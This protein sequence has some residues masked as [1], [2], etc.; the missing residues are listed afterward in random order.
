[1]GASLSMAHGMDK[2]AANPT[3]RSTSRGDWRLTFLHMALQDYSTWSTT[4]AT[5]PCCLLDNRS[6]G[7]TG[8]QENPGHRRGFARLP[9]RA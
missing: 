8:G 7:M 3:R 4:G 5:S 6:V 2:G 9:A 1:M